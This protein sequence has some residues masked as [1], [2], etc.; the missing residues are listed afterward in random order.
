[1]AASETHDLDQ[2]ILRAMSPATGPLGTPEPALLAPLVS[3]YPT[4]LQKQSNVED[5][6]P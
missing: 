6:W 2:G 4:Q 1:M 3:Q 5:K